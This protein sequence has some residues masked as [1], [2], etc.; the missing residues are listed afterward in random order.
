MTAAALLVA[1]VAVIRVVALERRLL[2][3]AR[4]D[5]ELRGPLTSLLMAVERGVPYAT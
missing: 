2:L 1:L 5:H 3:V 4:A